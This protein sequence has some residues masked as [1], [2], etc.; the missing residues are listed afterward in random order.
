MSDSNQV[1]GYTEDE[2][3]LPDGIPPVACEEPT[4]EDRD[5]CL[6]HAET[7]QKPVDMLADRWEDSANRLDGIFLKGL[8]LGDRIDFSNKTLYAGEFAGADLTEANFQGAQL[9]SAC[10]REATLRSAS[11]DG[12]QTSLR[13]AQFEDSECVDTRFQHATLHNANFK[14]A[15]LSS[16]KFQHADAADAAFVDS[17][18]H[19]AKLIRANFR[20]AEL[21]TAELHQSDCG[22]AKFEGASLKAADLRGGSFT[23]ADLFDVDLR[24]AE[25]DHETDF[26]SQICREFSADRD[27]EWEWIESWTNLPPGEICTER[28]PS[29]D[30]DS[31]YSDT[32]RSKREHYQ[33]QLGYRHRMVGA[34]SRLLNRN[35]RQS[36]RR[37]EL[38]KL[39]EAEGIYRDIKQ[40]YRENPV[41]EQRRNFN[42]REKEV[43]RKIS[44]INGDFSWLRWSA[45][46]WSMKYGES[47]KQVIWASLG[48]ILLCSLLYPIW[49]L[50]FS[51][52][53]TVRYS[54]AGGVSVKSMLSFL[55]YSLRRLI[56]PTNGA[57]TPVGPSE[58][59]ALGETA[60]GAL[61]TAML[62]FVLGRR[63]TS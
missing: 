21:D 33:E 29:A 6:W 56:S 25:V 24:D 30:S 51:S 37:P 2:A 45:L 15:N 36:S 49:G 44:Y 41:P 12:D 39:K 58:W 9:D 18:L 40:L 35:P 28:G 59:I 10:F 5:R 38:S 50:K 43:K 60:L 63:A 13:K 19:D 7:P 32:Y 22:K 4:W 3:N 26:G 57:V 53:E 55:F 54:L 48:V 27:A 17:K 20:S 62:V 14:S 23:D 8:R 11:F 46:R 31:Q 16:A 61:L 52:Q 34:L 42:I 1:C 47:A